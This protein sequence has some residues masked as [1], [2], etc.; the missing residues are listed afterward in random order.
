MAL[1]FRALMESEQKKRGHRPLFTEFVG[2]QRLLMYIVISKPNRTSLY[3]GVF[4]AMSV[5]FASGRIESIRIEAISM[6]YLADFTY[7][8]NML[9]FSIS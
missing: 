7:F 9:A 6:P 2:G 4:Q 5:S 3:A 1:A 8:Q